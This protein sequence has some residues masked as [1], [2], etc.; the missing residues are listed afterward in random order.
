MSPTLLAS[1][2]ALAAPPWPMTEQ[3]L[4]EHDLARAG[5]RD[6]VVQ[7]EQDDDRVTVEAQFRLASGEPGVL[8]VDV[9]DWDGEHRG[10]E[11]AFSVGGVPHVWLRQ[12]DEAP[13]SW[14][15]PDIEADPALMLSYWAVVTDLRI[16]D[17][18]MAKNPACGAMKWGLRTLARIAA[19]ACCGGG[20]GVGC[21]VCA[22]GVYSAD[23]AIAGIDC[24]KECKP[25]CPIP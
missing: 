7:F 24:N 18:P 8:R 14:L 9:W 3:P 19:L 17:E 2:V 5:P 20:F 25:D 12:V 1:V 15:S 6:L 13:E 11:S 21:V 16:D 22:V 23:D 10:V 4:T